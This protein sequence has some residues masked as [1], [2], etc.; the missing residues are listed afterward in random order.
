MMTMKSL[1][2]LI[3]LPVLAFVGC[4]SGQNKETLM[5]AAGF[6]T[7]IPSSPTQIS[8]SSFSPRR[9]SAPVRAGIVFPLQA[10]LPPY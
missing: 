10:I 5:S 3:L 7:I 8:R 1:R 4:S 6:R 2:S 9:N